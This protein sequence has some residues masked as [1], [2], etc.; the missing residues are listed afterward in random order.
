MEPQNSPTTERWQKILSGDTHEYAAFVD[1]YKNLITSIAYSCTGDLSGSED[2]AQE[3][4]LIAWQ[5]RHEVRE[6]EKLAGWLSSIARNLARQWVRKRSARS[7]PSTQDDMGDVMQVEPHPSEKLVSEEEQELVWRSLEAI[8]ESYREVMVLYYRESHSI[9]EVASVLEITE[10]AARQRLSRGRGL[11]RAEVERTIEHTLTNSRPTARFT[12]GVIVLITM[13]VGS[14]VAKAAST[15]AVSSAAASTAATS[16]L[17][18]SIA[19][20]AAVAV[21]QTATTGAMIG[22]AGAVTGI[23]GGLGG[24]WLGTRVPQL[25]APT[26]TERRLLE[27]EGRMAWRLTCVYLSFLLFTV[28]LGLMFGH[29]AVAR[30]ISFV[31]YAV[32]TVNFVA[33]MVVRG[34]LVNRQIKKIRETI[35]PEDDPNPSWLK[36]KLG[37]SGKANKPK[38]EGRRFTS[39]LRLLGWPLYDFQVS[40]PVFG[41]VTPRQALHA[42]G[43]IAV[44]DKATGLLAV[45][46]FA[47]GLIAIGGVCFGLVSFGALSIGLLTLGGLSIGLLATGGL[48]IGH[49][50]VGGAAL[51][52]QSMGGVAVGI[53]SA[54]GGLAIGGTLAEGGK[55]IS[56]KYAIGGSARAPEANTEAARV[57]CRE[58]WVSPFIGTEL[59]LKDQ[60]RFVINQLVYSL[61]IPVFVS[62]LLGG[63]SL[64]MYRRVKAIE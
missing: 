20:G 2:I 27:R 62:L 3:T 23:L 26:M 4:F 14:T 22:A 8:P 18:K 52:W 31:G 25:L 64:S 59:L 56:G 7:W 58:S 55:A 54:N 41:Q 47:R 45:G 49:S 5:S 37:T 46:N 29:H 32:T 60:K 34:I 11:L 9:A 15:A 33:F 10:D 16:V 35:C 42:K 21:A 43:W 53:Y 36:D 24:T 50:S 61:A 13:G 28:V 57:A 1:Q 38:L 39:R 63:F 19:Q 44:G 30:T 12:S 40:D 48:A 17:S 51:G 6:P